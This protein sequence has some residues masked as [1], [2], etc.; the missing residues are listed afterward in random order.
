MSGLSATPISSV[1][2]QSSSTSGST[3]LRADAIG[4][5]GV[6]ATVVS[7]AA[8]LTVMAGVAPVALA[9]GGVGVPGAYLLAGVVL[10]IFAIGFTAMAAT[11]RRT[12]GFFVYIGHAFGG[13]AGFAA[14]VLALA[15][16]NLLQIGVYGLFG[17]QTQA[18]LD[19]LFGVSAP[20]WLI[21]AIAVVLVYVLGAVGI[22]VGAKVLVV[23]ITLESAILA[24]MGVAIIAQGG[25]DGFGLASFA[26]DNILNGGVLAVL[27]IC[28]AAFM[29]F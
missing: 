6:A 5:V 12:G 26:P 17:I 4:T 24:L 22:D 19:D 23:L 3:A 18:A 20:W 8:P 2:E 28:F 11:I 7:A 16:Y 15:S 9:I 29:G 21:A 25:A 10:C 13:I 14:A 1:S 27:G